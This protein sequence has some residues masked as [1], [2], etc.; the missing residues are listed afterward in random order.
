MAGLGVTAFVEVSPHPVLVTGIGQTLAELPG[1]SK[2]VV[3]GTLRRGEGGLRRFGLSLAQLHVR[4][5]AVDWSRWFTGVGARPVELPTYAFQH[6]RYWPQ[7][8]PVAVSGSAG[9]VYQVRWRPAAPPIPRVPRLAGTWLVLIPPEG[10][11]R[12]LGV[13][14]VQALSGRGATVVLVPADPGRAGRAELAG[15]LAG[16]AG[17]RPVTGVVSLLAVAEGEAAGFPAVPAGVAGT[18][19]LV[20][21]LGDAG[22]AGRLWCLTRTAVAACPEDGPGDAVQGQVW[23]LGRV[24]GLE[25]PDR[26]GG[27]ADLPPVW[28]GRTGELLCAVLAASADE[29]QVA[30][31]GGGLLVRRLERAGPSDA[32]VTGPGWRPRGTVLVTGGTGALGA[33]VSR[34]A[35][36]AGARRVVL[37]S[38]SGPGAAGTPRLAVQLAGRGADALVVTCDTADR[39][40]VAG[41]L[42]RLAGDRRVPLTAVVHAAGMAG[43]PAL[44]AETSV[45]GLAGVLAGKA[46]GAAW[47]DELLGGT[48]LD[49]FVLF[50]SAAGVWGSVGQA[51]YA[52]ANAFLDTLAARRRARGLAA[53]S[54]AWG[55]WSGAGMGGEPGGRRLRQG[56]MREM[57]P[58][59][60]VAALGRAVT[61]G[62]PCPVVADMDWERFLPVFSAARRRPLF[63]ALPEAA[64]V[65]A[66]SQAAGD[67]GDAGGT[68]LDGPAGR[69]GQRETGPSADPAG[70]GGS[71][72]G[73]RP[74][75]GRGS[76]GWACV[77]RDRVRLADRSRVAGPAGGGDRT[78]AARQPG[79]RLPHPR[80]T[81][82]LPGLAASRCPGGG[83]RG[84]GGR[85]GGDR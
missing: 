19:V 9:W 75:L 44:V 62:E 74:P 16:L 37:A 63:D 53:T 29:D 32:A 39:G 14:C 6:Q 41:L 83:S 36:E 3:T 64:Q 67:A 31:R 42:S 22:I 85:G 61:A 79:L 73:A 66:G 51:G 48:R 11:G 65:L 45:A 35:A 38:R 72:G 47:L 8:R 50:S 82:Q 81:G 78:A 20:Q 84:S 21:A 18:L 27:L 49:A 10:E 57:A 43:E 55:L 13:R 60:A 24:A 12:R 56:G 5:V 46:A 26:W 59:A 25:H 40:A 34:W 54:V 68:E 77:Q 15:Q 52:A 30:I 4:G 28:D 1:P 58:G 76:P 7:G 2:A 33:H 70:A 80:G 23:A 69:T 71:G 17:S